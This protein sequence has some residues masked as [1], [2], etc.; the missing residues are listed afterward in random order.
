MFR[1][2]QYELQITGQSQLVTEQR[3]ALVHHFQCEMFLAG[4]GK[5]PIGLM[6]LKLVL[7]R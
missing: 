3:S 7:E 5:G 4:M 1:R 6:R 2:D